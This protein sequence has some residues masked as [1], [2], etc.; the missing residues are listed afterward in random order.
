VEQ[1]GAVV[2]FP[3]DADDVLTVLDL[4]RDL[5]GVDQVD[6]APDRAVMTPQALPRSSSDAMTAQ[7][8]SASS[9]KSALGRWSNGGVGN[10]SRSSP[11]Y[12]LSG[13]VLTES[14]SSRTQPQTVDR[15]SA[16]S[17]VTGSAAAVA[18]PW[19][20]SSWSRV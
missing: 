11:R 4:D 1:V 10:G 8:Q 16:V 14:A 18:S 17:T 13:N 15:R 20:A 9:S 2:A 5:V 7:S 3:A 6:L 19:S 12:T